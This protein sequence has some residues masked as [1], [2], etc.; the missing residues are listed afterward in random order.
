MR[1]EQFIIV[2]LVAALVSGFIIVVERVGL[3]FILEALMPRVAEGSIPPVK[4]AYEGGGR[5]EDQI[6]DAKRELTQKLSEA[7]CKYIRIV[8]WREGEDV[9]I[10]AECLSWR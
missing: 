10:V 8:A 7:G 1:K 2:L 3:D 5:L 9:F 4:L 6:R